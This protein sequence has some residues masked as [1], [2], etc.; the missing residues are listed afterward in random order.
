MSR[1]ARIFAYG[2]AALVA[3]AG[4]LC[5]AFIGGVAGIVLGVALGSLGLGAIV[6]LVFL[7]VGLSEDRARA[8]EQPPRRVPPES[9]HPAHTAWSSS[10]RRRPRR[11]G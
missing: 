10:S 7:E 1:R 6:L 9:P 3:L 8:R 2:S 4:A 11:R 5:A